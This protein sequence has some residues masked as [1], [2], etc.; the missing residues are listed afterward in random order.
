MIN[1]L[2]RLQNRFCDQLETNL[3]SIGGGAI[4][5]IDH[6]KPF[7]DIDMFIGIRNSEDIMKYLESINKWYLKTTPA[8][9]VEQQVLYD[10]MP[11]VISVHNTTWRF[12]TPLQ[13]VFVKVEATEQEAFQREVGNKFDFNINKIFLCNDGR[14]NTHDSYELDK[15]NRTITLANVHSPANLLRAIEKYHRL[16]SDKY[17]GYEF[18]Y[19]QDTT[20]HT[21]RTSSIS[22]RS[23]SRSSLSL[24]DGLTYNGASV[25]LFRDYNLSNITGVRGNSATVYVDF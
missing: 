21:S 13:L 9:G 15:S 25:S 19:T 24:T 18:K 3:V 14:Q 5:D 2:T 17:K 22:P 7:K 16:A 4:R 23:S 10:D 1:D 20:L 12:S 11:M 6:D 8:V